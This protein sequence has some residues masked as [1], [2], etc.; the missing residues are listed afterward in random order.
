MTNIPA[1]IV[2]MVDVIYAKAFGFATAL[3]AVGVISMAFLQT[4]KDVLPVRRWFQAA[5]VRGWLGNQATQTPPIA[6]GSAAE[7]DTAEADLVRLATSGDRS[8]LYD[9]PIE[10]VT[11]QMNAAAQMVL[12]FPWR[13][14][15][16]FRCLA[17]QADVDDIRRLLDAHPPDRGPRRELSAE[18]KS[19]LIDARNR[20]THQV[21][22]SLDGLMIS[23]GFRWKLCLQI[24]SIVVSALTVWVGLLLFVREP[25]EVFVRHLPVYV[26]ISVLGGFLAPVARDLVAALQQLRK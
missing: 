18:D 2:Q 22:R 20:V 11:G 23:A 8:A 7:A 19:A 26:V 24:A 9:L 14:E 6:T 15:H 17:A 16:L 1:A 13:H 4:V 21:Q 10:Q 25:I 5:W 12:D 3:A